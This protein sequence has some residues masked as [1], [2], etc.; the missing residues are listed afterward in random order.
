M[1]STRQTLF[2]NADIIEVQEILPTAGAG[3]GLSILS[4]E[5]GTRRKEGN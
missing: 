1:V 2:A 4:Q 5:K 3:A